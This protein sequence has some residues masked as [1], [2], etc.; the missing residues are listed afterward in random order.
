[1]RWLRKAAGQGDG[2]ARMVLG[3]LHMRDLASVRD[4]VKS[5]M[6]L[7]LALAKVRGQKRQMALKM[8]ALVTA[9]MTPTEIARAKQMVR[10]WKAIK[11]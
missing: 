8:R 1:M 3:D 4:Y 9:K 11:R 10:D 6:W 7:T 2:E 5:Y